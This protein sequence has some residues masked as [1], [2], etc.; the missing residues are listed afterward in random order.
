VLLLAGFV[1]VVYR[2][3][4]ERMQSGK[5]LPAF[6][7]YSEQG[8]GLGEAAHLLRQ[9]G[10]QAEPLTRLPIPGLERGLLIVASPE[11]AEVGDADARALLAWVEAGNT[12]LLAGNQQTPLHQA[13]DL[14]VQRPAAGEDEPL[15]LAP[16]TPGPY[17]EGIDRL[18]VLDRASLRGP[19]ALP[20]WW[21]GD[22]PGALLLRRGKG[23]VLA[24]ADPS[25]LTRR[26]LNRADNVLFLVNVV[27][28]DARGGVVY[29]DEYHHGFRS[30][31]GFWGYLGH[32]R[33]QLTLLPLLVVVGAAL[34][35][36]AVRLGPAVPVP[37]ELRADAVD[38]ASAL[39]RLYETTGARR[40]LARALARGFLESLT[41][42]LRIRRNALPAEV[43]SAWRQAEPATA[44]RLQELLRGV[45]EL[46]RGDVAERDLLHWA[47]AFDQ[48]QRE[49]LHVR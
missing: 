4:D 49:V 47:R 45:A 35:M 41:R 15:T 14:A 23:R 37:P 29:F 1:L 6:S 36:L 10:W 43:L 13:L 31:G 24:V 12:L 22:R 9:L 5:G 46:R 33:Q 18:S 26:G 3:L 40:R 25:L 19:D 17:T 28:H 38:Y 8:D 32:Y 11:P 42:F 2:V 48:F 34:W 39:A 16:D 27:E 44:P 21:V 20:L 7:V 30:S